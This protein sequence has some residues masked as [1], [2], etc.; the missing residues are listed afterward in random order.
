MISLATHTHTTVLMPPGPS[1]ELIAVAMAA[2]IIA[3][4][5]DF[6]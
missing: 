1:P 6:G 2:G 3:V 4:V 5:M